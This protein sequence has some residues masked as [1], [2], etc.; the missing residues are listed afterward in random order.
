MKRPSSAVT[1]VLSLVLLQLPNLSTHR[2]VKAEVEIN[3]SPTVVWTVLTDFSSYFIWNPYI[4]PAK[5][6]AKPGAHLELTLH[7]GPKPIT[8]EPTVVTA[9][10]NQELSWEGHFG[11]MIDRTEV[12]TIEAVDPHHVR[13]I[14]RGVFKGILLPLVGGLPDDTQR[15]L[16]QMG[17]AL[18]TRAEFLEPRSVFWR[19][20][21]DLTEEPVE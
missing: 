9:Q 2:E 1:I 11:G 13:L 20:L 16:D 10:P 19:R 3:A 8:F 6:V 15:G 5:G 17:R 14:A 21:V 7:E 4:Y 18:R 12:F